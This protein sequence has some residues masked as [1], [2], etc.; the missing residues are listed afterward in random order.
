MPDQGLP[1]AAA[2]D[3]RQSRSWQP[4][5]SGALAERAVTAA[6][7]VGATL[8]AGLDDMPPGEGAGRPATAGSVSLAA[9]YAGRALLHEYLARAW[10]REDDAE[11]AWRLLALAGEAV[12]E[13]GMSPSLYSG[14]SGVAWVTEHLSAAA[15]EDAAED[16]N[17]EIDRAL[18]ACLEQSPWRGDY[19]LIRGLVGLGVYALERLPR[20]TALRCLELVLARLGESAEQTA[21]GITWKTAPE[22][23]VPMQ[24]RWCPEGYYNLGVAHG[25]PGV[26][27]LLAAA[28]AAGVGRERA[29][30]LLDGAVSWVRSRAIPG[31]S[32][33]AFPAWVAPG[34]EPRPTRAAW[35]YGDPGVAATL[36]A[37]A[38][39]VGESAWEAHALEI[40][41]AAAAR[42]P[43]A[44]GVHDA[45]LCH[46]AA[47]LGHL[48]NRM[49][50]TTGDPAL[51]DAARAWFVR[52]LDH[53]RTGR[54][55]AGFAAWQPGP[56]GKMGWHD[57]PGF[58][59]GAAGVALALLAAATDVEPHWDRV[60]LLS[61][62]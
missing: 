59:T 8:R 28:W 21:D 29:R 27:A 10:G 30:P 26:V 6:R 46:G 53:A 7:R 1:G 47:G 41:R 56:D 40:G 4:V 5:L 23:L 17:E 51:R 45:C 16:A 58:L 35:C 9:G 43:D 49:F 48:Y 36:L 19:D 54:G 60:M 37:A 24:R 2:G 44:A 25:V 38:R 32:G 3:T 34:A 31:E 33:S 14:F 12:A 15:T 50:Q 22:L 55:V 57:D 42:P 52:A 18:V 62:R 13:V 39:C 61:V 11:T 20:A